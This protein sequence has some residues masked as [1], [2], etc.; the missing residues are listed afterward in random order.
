MPRTLSTTF[1]PQLNAK[2]K[3]L[4]N[5]Q[6][7]SAVFASLGFGTYRLV[8]DWNGADFLAMPFNGDLPLKVQLKTR[9]IISNKYRCKDLYICFRHGERWYLF[10]HDEVFNYATKCKNVLQTKGWELG[11]GTYCWPSPPKWLL[12]ILGPF[13]LKAGWTH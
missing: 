9:V 4:Y 6:C 7:V 3:E 11:K 8:D 1:Y 2:Q 12:N 5:F 13:E 10:P